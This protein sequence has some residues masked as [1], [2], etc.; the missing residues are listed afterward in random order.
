MHLEFY[1]ENLDLKYIILE[2]IK[3]LSN[4][5]DLRKI[6]NDELLNDKINDLQQYA[7]VKYGMGDI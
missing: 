2:T 7:D 6:T 4:E 1:A 5:K 3:V